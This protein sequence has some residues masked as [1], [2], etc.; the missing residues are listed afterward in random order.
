MNCALSLASRKTNY[1]ILKSYL[2]QLWGSGTSLDLLSKNLF[3]MELCFDAMLCSNFGNEISDSGHIKC[4]RGPQVPQHCSR[5][6]AYSSHQ[7]WLWLGLTR[8]GNRL[9]RYIPNLQ[10]FWQTHALENKV[11]LW[12]LLCC[13]IRRF[14]C[15]WNY[16]IKIH[17]DDQGI[18]PSFCSYFYCLLQFECF[19]ATGNAAI[20]Q[21]EC[22]IVTEILKW[23]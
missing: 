10:R 7:Q 9:A 5:G 23:E 14:L 17:A 4:S 12:P 19:T 8:E 13:V 22:S 11:Q 20:Q 18:F 15:S 16:V 1:F 2:Y 21:F 6:R 3:I